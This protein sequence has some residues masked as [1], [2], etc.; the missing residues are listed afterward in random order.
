MDPLASREL[1]ATGVALTPLG[2][3]GAPLGELFERL[4]EDAAAATVTAACEAGVGYFDTAPW[5]GHGL[6]EHRM[7]H[8]LRRRPRD[9]FV[10]STKVG[11]VYRAPADPATFD[12][13]PWA[14]GL[15]FELRFDYGYNGVLRS[16]EDSL[17]RLGLP[18]VDLLLIHDLDLDY[19]GGEA[20][21]EARYRELEAGGW[22]ALTEL[23]ADGL[24]KA[25]G[26]GINRM[27]LIPRF[28]DRLDID[29]FLVAMPYTLLDQAVLEEE[30]PRCLD[31][32]VGIVI[33]SPLASGIL[34]TGAGPDA[35]YGYGP[36]PAAVLEKLRGIQA[37]A[38][39]HAVPL[40]AAAL[41]F[42]L[43]HP[44]VAAVVPGAVSPGQVAANLA[45][46]RHDI[47]ADFWSELKA[48]S[49]LHPAAPCP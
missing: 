37:V 14:G 24:I 7:G 38:A 27:G 8:V 45:A 15:P 16:Y 49:L 6:S 28:L 18:R 10:L 20:G 44:A 4:P 12:G 21:W 36:P 11:R 13:A 41:Q 32:G 31:R 22:R 9:S 40:A 42:P 23:K 17:Q 25:I 33:G 30:F 47:P 46:M 39:R 43:G 26:A 34:A 3:G 48:E 29:F 1:G 5:Y 35:K 2:L 19:H